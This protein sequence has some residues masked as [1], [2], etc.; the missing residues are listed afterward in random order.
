[1]PGE[2]YSIYMDVNLRSV[3]N[4]TFQRRGHLRAKSFFREALM[5]NARLVLHLGTMICA[6]AL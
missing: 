5:T 6:H 3:Y 2:C 4:Q 1:M